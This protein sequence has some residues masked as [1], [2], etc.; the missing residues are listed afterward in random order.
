M[1]TRLGSK[2]G[3]ELTIDALV[4]EGQDFT[5]TT[6][7]V[8]ASATYRFLPES[9]FQVY[10]LAGLG[11]DF[12]RREFLEGRYALDRVDV[13]AQVGLGAEIFIT[14]S[15]SLS[16][17]I[18]GRVTGNLST[19]AKMRTDCIATSGDMTG[20]CDNIQSVT[21]GEKFQFGAQFALGANIYF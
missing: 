15:I 9:S 13:G 11:A 14:D 16:G 18:R 21:P 6:V 20:F 3:M 4:G 17:D 1:R 2:F 10:A 12:T 19:E 8:F 5:Q 7:P